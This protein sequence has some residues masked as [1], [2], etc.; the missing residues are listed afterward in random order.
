MWLV[1]WIN[2]AHF[3]ANHFHHMFRICTYKLTVMLL[4]ICTYMLLWCCCAYVHM[5][6][7]M[8]IRLP[9]VVHMYIFVGTI[10]VHMYIWL[11]PRSSHICTY[12]LLVKKWT[13]NKPK[14][15]P[16][17]NQ[18]LS[19]NMVPKRDRSKPECFI[20]CGRRGDKVAES[21]NFVPLCASSG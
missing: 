18:I 12:K 7:H 13:K 4:C 15:G 6:V 2:F 19:Q 11:Y 9:F 5:T 8:Y 16:Q 20:T 1:F 3:W 10:V 17:K 21:C 14:N